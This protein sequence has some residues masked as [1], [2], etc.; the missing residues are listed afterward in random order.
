MKY[1]NIKL[2]IFLAIFISCEKGVDKKKIEQ[3][4]K[5]DVVLIVNNI[6]V[7]WKRDNPYG[8]YGSK[9]KSE[10]EYSY[11]GLIKYQYFPKVHNITDTII[12]KNVDDFIEIKHKYK[13]MDAFYYLA[14]PFDTLN[15]TYD[16][17]KPIVQN[18]NVKNAQEGINY[19]Y[20]IREK[21]NRNDFLSF[22]KSQNLSMKFGDGKIDFSTLLLQDSIFKMLHT[23][24]AKKELEKQKNILDSL[25]K[26]HK[27]SSE[28]LAYYKLRNIWRNKLLAISGSSRFEDFAQNDTLLVYSF[29][30]TY[31]NSLVDKIILKTGSTKKIKNSE[32]KTAEEVYNIVNENP[33]LTYKTKEYLSFIWIQRVIEHGSNT[34]IKKYFDLF[35]SK[36]ANNPHLIEHI[37]QKFKL[38][39]DISND[40]TLVDKN[41][42]ET[43]LN[44]FIKNN[45]NKVIY[46]DYWASWCAPC[47][48]AMKY[49]KPLREQY[50]NENIV[51]LYLALN[52]KKEAWEEASKIEGLSGNNSFFITNS[53]TSSLIDDLNIRTIP[54]YMIYNKN[55]ELIHKNAPEPSTKEIKEIIDKLLQK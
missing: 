11:D 25:N 8:G 43:T 14:K 54:R 28:Y 35:K 12:V 32:R 10:L 17:N 53:K 1:F 42:K 34:K 33:H 36:Y 31:I 18:L 48:R 26:Q 27:I 3:Q 46:V 49:A 44:D 19:E 2:I 22:V 39:V 13:S 55:G 41:N 45:K 47:R 37:N 30:R 40:L 24:K 29:Y 5:G 9:G 52:D 4:K 6:P 38:N 20:L 7:N 23:K 16:I 15:F 50:K 21:V 51:F